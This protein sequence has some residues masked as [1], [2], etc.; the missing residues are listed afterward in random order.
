[1]IALSPFTLAPMT[2]AVQEASLHAS[3]TS[4]K[5]RARRLMSAA[6]AAAAPPPGVANPPLL[7][8]GGTPVASRTTSFHTRWTM[9]VPRA[10]SVCPLTVASG[11]R[12]SLGFVL[13][14]LLVV[15][16]AASSCWRDST[17][18]SSLLQHKESAEGASSGQLFPA[19]WVK[20]QKQDANRKGL[21][22]Q[23]H[24]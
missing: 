23:D 18:D 21:A 8:A 2:P 1:M 6:S 15:L 11:A 9:L 12:A 7:A 3:P 14:S 13:G 24:C 19:P 22:P 20:T 16:A 4:I 17:A 5:S 10:V